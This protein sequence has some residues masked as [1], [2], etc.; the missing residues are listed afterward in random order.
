MSDFASGR[1]NARRA[2]VDRIRSAHGAS[3]AAVF[4]VHTKSFCRDSDSPAPVTSYGPS[5]IALR[6]RGMPD[7]LCASC[8]ARRTGCHMF[9]SCCGRSTKVK[10]TSCSPAVTLMRG[11]VIR[12]LNSS[13]GTGVFS[14]A[15][16]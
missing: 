8:V 16:S 10:P 13:R 3:C 6:S 11:D 1:R 2:T 7:G 14:V 15:A 4:G 5:M 9:C 12:L